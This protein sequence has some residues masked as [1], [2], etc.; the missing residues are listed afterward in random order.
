MRIK[1]LV[2]IDEHLGTI[3]E[4][5]IMK[6]QGAFNEN[7]IEAFIEQLSGDIRKKVNE[8]IENKK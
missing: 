3:Y 1:F 4:L 8:Y 7:E 6:V 2:K 5:P